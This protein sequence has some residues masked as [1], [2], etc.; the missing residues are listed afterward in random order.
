MNLRTHLESHHEAEYLEACE[1][2]DWPIQLAKRKR[3]E[4]LANELT[5]R[6][7]SLDGVAVASKCAWANLFG[8]N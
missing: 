6:Q 1:E 3:R 2:N 5:L 4:M 7:S 8:G